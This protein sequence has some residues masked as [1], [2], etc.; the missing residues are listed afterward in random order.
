[1]DVRFK[2]KRHQRKV[3]H[4]EIYKKVNGDPLPK[5]EI[6][7]GTYSVNRDYVLC[8]GL[9]M[10]SSVW[11]IGTIT[12]LSARFC[13]FLS[14]YNTPPYV[15]SQVIYSYTKVLQYTPTRLTLLN[16]IHHYVAS[17]FSLFSCDFSLL[18]A[19]IFYL[20]IELICYITRAAPG[21]I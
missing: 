21:Y 19:W 14:L 7:H 4:G 18:C 5:K 11:S 6:T 15:L 3:F 17:F 10:S 20:F 2:D 13:H 8:V 9:R 1:M 16:L 12:L